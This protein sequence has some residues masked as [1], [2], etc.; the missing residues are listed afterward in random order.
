MGIGWAGMRIGIMGDSHGDWPSV[1]RAVSAMDPVDL[2]LHTGD[3]CRDAV[4]LAAI[5]GLSVTS[6]AGNC[7]GGTEA[8]PDE[9]LELAGYN[10]WLTHGHR[11]GVKQNLDE[12][13]ECACHY[14]V[15]IVIY[16]HTHQANFLREADLVLIN[17]GSVALPRRGKNRTCGIL[18]LHSERNGIL[19]NLISIS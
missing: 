5:S 17:P 6:V 8:K 18:E 4:F 9:F 10:I 11:H 14:G 19:F 7:D 16:G 12:L 15:D 13:H 2:W 1:K 3:F